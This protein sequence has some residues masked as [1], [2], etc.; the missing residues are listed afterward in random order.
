MTKRDK[1]K[2]DNKSDKKGKEGNGN[3][4]ERWNLMQ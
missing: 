2:Q 1:T 4:I 3:G